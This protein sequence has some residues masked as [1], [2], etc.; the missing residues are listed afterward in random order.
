MYTGPAAHLL[1]ET[2]G[3]GPTSSYCGENLH[4]HSAIL[5]CVACK[6]K[7]QKKAKKKKIHIIELY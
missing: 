2:G 4:G 3:P 7:K 6:K 1:S 5:K